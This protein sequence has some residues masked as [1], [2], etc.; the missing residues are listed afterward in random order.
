MKS[1]KWW[2]VWS[3]AAL[4]LGAF[5]LAACERGN[6]GDGDRFTDTQGLYRCENCDE[7]IDWL[8]QAATLSME[9]NLDEMYRGWWGDD[10]YYGDDDWRDDDAV[11]GGDEDATGG[12][13]DGGSLGDDDANGGDAPEDAGGDEDHTDTNVQEEGVDEADVVKTDGQYLYLATGGYLLIYDA[14]PQA[15]TYELSRVEIEGYVTEM[16][17]Y[18]DVALVFS[19]LYADDVPE[20]IWPDVDVDDLFYT[21]TKLTLIDHSNKEF[22]VIVRELFVEGELV[23]SRMIDGGARVVTRASKDG[24]DIQYYLEDGDYQSEEAMNQAIARL[25]VENR[26]RIEASTL[27][28]WVP[29]FFSIL[30]TNDG[31]QTE[32]GLLSECPDHYR[33][34]E[35]FGTSILSVLT[36]RLD[37]PTARQTD[38]SI[39]ADG[40]IVYASQANLYVAG[41]VDAGWFW[42]DDAGFDDAS[43]IHRFDIETDPAEALYKGSAEVPGW[44]LN[45]FAMSEWQGHLRVATTYGGWRTGT[46]ER[47]GVFVLQLNDENGL[48]QVGAV[49]NLALDESIYA[50]RMIGPRGFL[51]TFL[52][53]D[54]LFTIDLSDPQHPAMVGELEVPGFSTYLHPLDDNHLLAVGVGGDEWGSDGTLV[55]SIFDVT[56]FAAPAKRWGHSFGWSSSDAQYDHHAFLYDP[57]RD[58]LAIPLIDG[59]GGGWGG[60]DDVPGVDPD[61]PEETEPGDEPVDDDD[62]PEPTDD[63]VVTDDDDTVDDDDDTSGDYFA[64]VVALHVTI[65]DG[66]SELARINH[67]DIEPELNGDDY[68]YGYVWPRRS[69]RIGDYLFT[70]SN[71]ALVVTDMDTWENDQEISLPWE[72]ED[73]WYG[74]GDDWGGEDE[75]GWGGDDAVPPEEDTAG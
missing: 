63:D 41:T 46:P 24:A 26:E 18:D 72:E 7:V 47:N 45:Q 57:T 58:L 14:A 1:A 52:Q 42:A 5:A 67:G 73:Y 40:Y 34:L 2:V 75:P 56:D 32:S 38:I 62:E 25:K 69:V 9:R 70:I 50:A 49:E 55:L 35:P 61:E 20:D 10:D 60:D 6:G 15:D 11:P 44:V 33:P 3:L 64:G 8:Q 66:F 39:I 27:E 12:D 37:D 53:T 65:D 36:V 31:P 54:P 16:Y 17:L 23:S 29:R 4:L 48:E 74:D 21:V 22:P 68:F 13:D 59:Y 43:P 51:V 19:R 71:C 28:D 30:Y